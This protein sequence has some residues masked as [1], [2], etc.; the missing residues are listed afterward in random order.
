M[1]FVPNGNVEGLMNLRANTDIQQDSS[2]FTNP[3]GLK[4]FASILDDKFGNSAFLN[5][6]LTAP[7]GTKEDINPFGNSGQGLK[8]INYDNYYN[9]GNPYSIRA[10]EV[11]KVESDGGGGNGHSDDYNSSPTSIFGGFNKGTG[12]AGGGGGL[13]QK[14]DFSY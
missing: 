7:T 11:T 10:K 14:L 4:D 8:Q 5:N 13:A 6:I 12:M 2:S 1:T 9:K 3:F